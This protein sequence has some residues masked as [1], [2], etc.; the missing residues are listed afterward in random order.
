MKIMTNGCR[1]IVPSSASV[2]IDLT[3]RLWFVAMQSAIQIMPAIIYTVQKAP[4]SMLRKFTDRHQ[5]F[6]KFR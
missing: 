2:T 1:N 5:V 3:L 4:I 6:E